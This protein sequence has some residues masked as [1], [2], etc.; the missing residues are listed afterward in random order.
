MFCLFGNECRA[1]FAEDR[2]G[3]IGTDFD[4]ENF[5]I[6]IAIR[7]GEARFCSFYEFLMC[8]IKCFSIG[9]TL[10]MECIVNGIAGVFVFRTGSY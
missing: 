8:F 4:K 9:I 5:C 10:F 3:G 1:V 7:Y 2:C 6:V